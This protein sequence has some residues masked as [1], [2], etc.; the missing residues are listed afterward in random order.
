MAADDLR[1]TSESV[2]PRSLRDLITNVLLADVPDRPVVIQRRALGP[3]PYSLPRIGDAVARVGA[4]R[5]QAQ[6]PWLGMAQRP[7]AV[8]QLGRLRLHRSRPQ[9]GVVSAHTA[10]AAGA[11]LRE[12]VKSCRW[13]LRAWRDDRDS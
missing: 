6:L 12:V 4:G 10:R 8:T 9:Y 11:D 3:D 13:V 5:S 1:S 7:P 2:H